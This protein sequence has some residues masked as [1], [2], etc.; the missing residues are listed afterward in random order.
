MIL[1]LSLMMLI[2][3]HQEGEVAVETVFVIPAGGAD[4]EAEPGKTP[5]T[6]EYSHEPVVGIAPADGH[7]LHHAFVK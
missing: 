7:G 3:M 4:V 6:L 1:F 5:G 2:Q